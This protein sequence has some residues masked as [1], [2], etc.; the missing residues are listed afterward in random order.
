MGDDFGVGLRK[1]LYAALLESRAERRVVLDYA[2][3]DEG[4]IAAI[5]YMRVRVGYGRKTVRRPTRVRDA[6]CVLAALA[7]GKCP[8]KE[9]VE[10]CD[11]PR[12]LVYFYA[13][14]RFKRDA[15]RVV[16]SV[17]KPPKSVDERSDRRLAFRSETYYSAHEETPLSKTDNT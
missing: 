16:A 10:L 14:C 17:L 15:R 6:D 12:L 3:V 8:R 13:F 5:G 1:E 7:F 4:E 9:I 11:L 2:V